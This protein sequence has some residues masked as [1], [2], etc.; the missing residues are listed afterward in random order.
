MKNSEGHRIFP[1]C[2]KG[3]Y[4]D[5]INLYDVLPVI[6]KIYS[7]SLINLGEAMFESDLLGLIGRTGT[8]A[9]SISLRDS[10]SVSS[11]MAGRLAGLLC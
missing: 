8:W 7:E 4:W 5:E 6:L 3:N 11:W 9:V 2:N 10:Y 1:L